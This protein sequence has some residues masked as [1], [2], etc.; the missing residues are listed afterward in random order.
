MNKYICP[1]CKGK[2]KIRDSINP[3]LAVITLGMTALIEKS[4]WVICNLCKGKGI[5]DETLLQE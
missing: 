5:L 3:F 1:N 2:G 4:C